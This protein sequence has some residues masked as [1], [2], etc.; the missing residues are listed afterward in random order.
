MNFTKKIKLLIFFFF[1][2]YS[3]SQNSIALENKILFK[4]D[5]E[6]ITTIDIYEEIKFLKT[7]NPEINSLSKEELFEISKNSILRDKIKKVEIMNYVDEL[8]VDD[9]FLLNSI[10]N[11]YSRVGVNSLESFKV[12]LKDN[13]LN[14]DVV[15]E[16]LIIELIWNDIIY[17]K[18]NKKVIIDK[19]KIRDEILKESQKEKQRELLLS[20]IIFDVTNNSEINDKYEKILLDIEKIGF[21]ETALIH[22]NSSSASNGG[23]IGWVKE[24][25]LNPKIKKIISRLQPGEFSKPIRTSSGFIIIKIENEREYVSSLN[26]DDKVKEVIKFKV[27]NQLDQFSSMYFNKLKKDF[28][29]YGL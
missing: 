15:K 29:I 2:F 21:K 1:I 18:F 14:Y 11:K 9:K 20:E 7:F 8:K 16:K 28:I 24:E 25:N 19:K 22:S 6:I 3:N 4:I 27:N 12:F 17:Q 26:L 13:N 23:S 10:K 5:N